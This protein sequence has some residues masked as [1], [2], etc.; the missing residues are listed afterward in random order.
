MFLWISLSA[1][2]PGYSHY[3]PLWS[4][5]YP[6]ADILPFSLPSHRIY[7]SSRYEFL[8]VCLGL[9]TNALPFCPLS[10]IISLVHRTGLSAPM[11]VLAS[12]QLFVS[13][14]TRVF[15][16]S[17]H[18]RKNS[19]TREKDKSTETSKPVI[20][21]HFHSL[22]RSSE[23]LLPLTRVQSNLTIRTSARMVIMLCNFR[24][25][26]DCTLILWRPLCCRCI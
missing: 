4:W 25:I 11:K 26:F 14:H 13:I 23:I 22:A 7:S 16:S 8:V 3:I 18:S 5:S 12:L 17:S 24:L 21:C 15:L 1:L 2:T 10:L 6:S 20:D 9:P 19:L